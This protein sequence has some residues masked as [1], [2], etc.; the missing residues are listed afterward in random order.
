M[1]AT[2]KQTFKAYYHTCDAMG[3]VKTISYLRWMQQ[4]AFAASAA[5][6]YDFAD[7]HHSGQLWLVRE[8]RLE[9]LAPL[10]YG[11]VVETTT[12]VSDIRRFRSLR[13]YEMRNVETTSLVARAT[14]D[15]VYLDEQTMYPVTIPTAM[16]RAFFPEGVP[17][18]PLP[19]QRFP[20]VPPPGDDL[21]ALHKVVAWNDLDMMWHVN[22]ATYMNYI[23][24]AEKLALE[25]C[26]W[27]V[28]RLYRNQMRVA[29]RRLRIE[30]VQPAEAGNEIEISTWCS[31]CTGLSALRHYEI[32]RAR[33]GQLLIRAYAA[34]GIR[35]LV[36]GGPMLIPAEI[37]NS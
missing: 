27:S 30:Y 33:D 36:T 9:I 12:Y 28:Q 24:E 17:D 21:F 8:S 13:A 14:T 29:S 11:D 1:P 37:C 6:G 18:K 26:G 31:E 3:Y 4:A 32:H 2:Y 35:H 5:V 10:K 22:N 34:W 19:R 7:Y 25:S 20:Q 16:Q 15:W 23:D